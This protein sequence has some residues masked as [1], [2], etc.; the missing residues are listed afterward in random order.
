MPLDWNCEQVRNH[1]E[2]CWIEVEAVEG[3][4]PC[5]RV[6]PTTETL[7]FYTM[8]LCMNHITKAN[9][10][11]FWFRLNLWESL[12]GASRWKVADNGPEPNYLTLEDVEAHI[13]LH[14]NAS[15]E[16]LSK[17]IKSV[18]SR[19]NERWDS[20]SIPCGL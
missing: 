11:E 15:K 19:F 14:T 20:C 9:H 6:N 12:F 7:V 10:M 3:E 2:T 1:L 16:P 18:Q 13:G 5:Y 17:W 8:D 4:D